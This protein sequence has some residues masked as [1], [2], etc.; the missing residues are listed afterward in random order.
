MRFAVIW[1][2]LA[3]SDLRRTGELT[4]LRMKL[5][6]KGKELRTLGQVREPSRKVWDS[7]SL[8]IVVFSDYRVQDISLLSHVCGRSIE[9]APD[10]C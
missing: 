10:A 9:S 4:I 8:R 2:W 3:Q 1:R 7:E 6:I 5:V